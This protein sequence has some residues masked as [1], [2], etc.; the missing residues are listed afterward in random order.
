MKTRHKGGGFL[1]GWNITPAFR[2]NK[3]EH[4]TWHKPYDTPHVAHK[5]PGSRWCGTPGSA[6]SYVEKWIKLWASKEVAKIKLHSHQKYLLMGHLG[7]SVGWASDFS[8]GH[9]LVVH[10]FQPCVQLWADSS[11]PGACF[12]FCVSLSHCPWPTR[13]L[14]LSLSKINKH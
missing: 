3:V 9:D 13:I 6:F 11:E 14:S 4:R 7:G 8:S 5:N 2:Y 1:C 10:E 12:C